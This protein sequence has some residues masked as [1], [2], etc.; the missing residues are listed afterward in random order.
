MRPKGSPAELERRRVRAMQLLREGHQP[1]EIAPILGVDRRSIR[2]WKFAYRQS[3][4]RGLKAIPATGR[5]PFLEVEQRRKL[6]RWILQGPEAFGFETSLWTCK[7]IGA[8]I[9]KQFG[10]SY[11]PRYI[12]KLLR[13]SGLSPQ[14]PQKVAKERSDQRVRIWLAKTWP[15][16]KKTSD[17]SART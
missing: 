1:H 3:G 11:H 14:R 17:A 13:R 10:V 9:R 15:A 16:V 12:S 6:V 7:R 2:R 4:R 8:L 5:P